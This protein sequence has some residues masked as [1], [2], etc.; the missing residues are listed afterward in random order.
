MM[1]LDEY[2][3]SNQGVLN[4]L[5]KNHGDKD[6]IAPSTAHPYPHLQ[7]G[8]HPDIVT[9]VWEEL[10][11]TLPMD[12]KAIVYGTP[13]L[14]NPNN[15][16]ILALA[17]GTAYVIK[18]PENKVSAA[19]ACGCK[20]EQ[21]WAGGAKTNVAELFGTGWLFGGWCSDEKLWLLDTYHD[22]A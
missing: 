20:A 3:P 17:Y 1:N 7:L 18:I 15:G 8:S 12:C 10:G 21:A 22:V 11:D 14:V 13:A 9:R 4:H 2:R 19:L 16:A 5:R 6:P